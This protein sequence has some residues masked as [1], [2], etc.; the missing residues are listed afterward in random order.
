MAVGEVRDQRWR[1]MTLCVVFAACAVG[2]VYRT[3]TY[4]VVEY[5]RFASLASEEHRLVEKIVPKRGD[6]LDRNGH[7]LAISVMYQSVYAD[8]MSV[9]DP[10]AVAGALSKLLN[11]SPESIAA[12]LQTSSKMPILLKRKLPAD[13]STKIANLSLPGIYLQQEPFRGYPEGSI[14]AQLLGFVGQ[15]FKGLAGLELSLDRDLG[16]EPGRLAAERDTVGGEI[17][18]GQRQLVPPQEGSDAILTID[19][20]IQRM[21]E[22]ELADALKEYK[23]R[24]GVIIIM[25]PKTGAIL[26]M[27]TQPTY[28][29]TAEEV[30]DPNHQEL[31]R[32]SAVTD[33]YEPGSVMKLVTMSSAMEEKL[34]TPDTTFMDTGVAVIDGVKIRNWD[35][36]AHGRESMTQVL[37]NSCNIG[38]QYVAG[39]LGPDRFYRYLDAF[40]FGKTTGVGLPGESPGRYRTPKEAEWTRVDLATNAYGQGIAVTPLQMITAVAAIANDGV[41]PKP[42]LVKAFRQGESVREIAPV[43]VRRVVSSETAKALTGMMVHVV[44]DNSLKL[45]VVPGYK[46]AGKTGTADLP[47]STGYTSGVTYASQV[48]FA[49]ADD[50]KFVM[51]VRIDGSPKQ[52]GG[53]VASPVFKKIAEQLFAY[54]RV[55]PSD[56]AKAQA[57]ATTAALTAPTPAGGSSP[58]IAAPAVP[59]APTKSAP[60]APAATPVATKTAQGTPVVPQVLA[61]SAPATPAAPRATPTRPAAATPVPPAPTQVPARPTTAPPKPP[62]PAATPAPSG[63]R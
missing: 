29:L 15:D 50:P 19:R 24:G 9:K 56:Q 42:M 55:A 4:Q 16:G 33:M 11:E 12:K 45:S 61:T 26:A 54:M 3:Y 23:A 37:I 59:P 18:I 39:L 8:P 46:I 41:L 38:A 21:A 22:R 17:A 27:A 10:G 32:P 30:F 20:Y 28:D 53:Q 6:I 13:V 51:L 5:Q 2:L 31:Y 25:E 36:G 58:A 44:E 62:A 57:A 48:G 7:P 14:A 60:A 34:V 40:G 47:T 35:L 63:N 1:L 52:Y 49:P 43:Q